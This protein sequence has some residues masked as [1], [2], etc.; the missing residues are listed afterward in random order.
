MTPPAVSVPTL[1]R[2]PRRPGT[3]W[4][5]AAATLIP[6]WVPPP[7]DWSDPAAQGREFLRAASRIKTI[8]LPYGALP[9][10]TGSAAY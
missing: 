6:V 3:A 10:G 4:A 2:R 7:R 9:A 8:W 5:A 1:S